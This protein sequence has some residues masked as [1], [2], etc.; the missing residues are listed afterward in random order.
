MI[1]AHERRAYLFFYIMTLIGLAMI[2]MGLLLLCTGCSSQRA[3]RATT[4][5]G[6][7]ITEDAATPEL[8]GEWDT[9]INESYT[10]G[11]LSHRLITDHR[12]KASPTN[13][14]TSA[15]NT[16]LAVLGASSLLA[17]P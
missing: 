4:A 17:A 14:I 7:S 2:A 6:A 12:A 10:S 16:L 13:I 11:T 8:I 9:A 15:L 5:P 3:H 1:Y